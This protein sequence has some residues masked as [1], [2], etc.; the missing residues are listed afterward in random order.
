ML[1]SLPLPGMV[2]YGR[3]GRV[4]RT[5]RVTTT[6]RR[7]RSART[8]TGRLGGRTGRR[9]IRVLVEDGVEDAAKGVGLH[10]LLQQ[11]GHQ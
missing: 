3:T 9:A 7:T 2:V 6:A 5:R 10:H 8:P 4:W 11:G 1:N